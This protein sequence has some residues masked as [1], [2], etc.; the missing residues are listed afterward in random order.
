MNSYNENLHA[1]VLSSLSEQELQLQ[2]TKASLDASMFSL[3]YAEGA[4]ITAA[5]ELQIANSNYAFQQLILEQAVI[6]SDVSTNMLS[7]TNLGNKLIST[8]VKNT[9]VAAANVQIAANAVLKLASDVG[10]IFSMVNAADFDTEIYTQSKEAYELMNKTAYLAEKTSQLSMEASAQIAEVPIVSLTDKAQ[11][12]DT[13]IKSL[14]EIV[15]TDFTTASNNVATDSQAL[16]TANSQE[17]S[18]EGTLQNTE[19]VYLS[20]ISAYELTNKELNLDLEV[21][22]PEI[23]GNATFYTVEFNKYKS[24][25]RYKTITKDDKEE[26]TGYPVKDYYIFLVKNKSKEIFSIS[27]AE[28]LI[29]ESKK[30]KKY[31]K[32][33]SSK[34]R[35]YSQDVYMSDLNDVDGERMKLGEKYVVFVFAVLENQYKKVINTFDD[36]L[37]APS[38]LFTLTNKLTAPTPEAISVSENVMTFSVQEDAEYSVEYRCIFL[39]NNRDLVKG[40]LTVEGLKSIEIQTEQLDD[41]FRKYNPEIERL[42]S[43]INDLSSSETGLEEQEEKNLEKQSEKGL[44]AKELKKLKDDY[45]KIEKEHKRV[46]KEIKILQKELEKVEKEKKEAIS[47]VKYPKHLKPGFFF[48]YNIAK[49][50]GIDSYALA[51]KESEDSDEYTLS[52]DSLTTD[53]FGNSLI[54][55]NVYIPAVLAMSNE[56]E[57]VKLQFVGALSDFQKTKDF[58]YTLKN[59]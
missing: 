2:K 38:A 19:A 54:P 52:I 34:E 30:E 12:T 10:S 29:M 42:E 17:K 26:E 23:S 4:R 24:P 53:N 21:V 50:L 39:P 48:N 14:L 7:S 41:V 9:S 43:E 57:N 47:S 49:G 27:D 44:D 32:I 8:S 45:N 51:E 55:G 22:L 37:S 28:G 46:E 35:K 33:P 3:Y 11:A 31:L 16:V 59:N 20:G 6:D 36:Y 40:L 56:E 1:S 18:A 13:S 25:F 5:E 58:T 15:T